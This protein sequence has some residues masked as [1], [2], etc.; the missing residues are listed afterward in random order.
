MITL[1]ELKTFL[2]IT[3]SDSDDQLN[4]AINSAIGFIASYVWY[5]LE[6]NETTVATFHWTTNLFELKRVNINSISDISYYEDEFDPSYTTYNDAENQRVWLDKWLV[7]TRE[8]IGPF[9]TITYSFWY[10]DTTCPDDLKTANL[11]IASTYFKKM[12]EISMQD[13]NS[14]SVDWDQ[15]SFKWVSWTITESS[16]SILDNYKS[17]EFS[18]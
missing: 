18:S 4:Q 15:I 3:N 7:K 8:A 9:V 1:A 14:E 5:S 6:L 11:E 13:L 16:L 12:W 2:K 10:D 17:Y